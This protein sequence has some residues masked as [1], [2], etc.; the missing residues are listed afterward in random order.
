MIKEVL[1]SAVNALPVK[2]ALKPP[3]GLPGRQNSYFFHLQ[4]DEVF[5][6]AIVSKGSIVIYIPAEFAGLG[7]ELA[8][9]AV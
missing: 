7:I 1:S 5:W 4:K 6:K 9:A 8:A 3:P 2:Y